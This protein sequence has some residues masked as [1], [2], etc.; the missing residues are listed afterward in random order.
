M[1]QNKGLFKKKL[2]IL[3]SVAI[4]FFIL[5][6]FLLIIGMLM[7]SIK[8]QEMLKATDK[9]INFKSRVERLIFTNKTLVQGF[10]AYLLMNP[11]LDEAEA[12]IY[13]DKL[14]SK[15]DNQ[16]RNIGVI[17]DTTIIWN[18]PKEGNAAAIGVDLSMVESQKDLIL[19]VKN[20]LEPVLQGPVDLVQGGTGFIIR[21]PI[22][23]PET[24]YWGQISIVLNGDKIIEEIN[25]YAA[26]AG[27]K[28]AI[29]NDQN[30]RVPF[31]G[32]MSIVGAAP[33][34][35]DI[36][37]D[38]INWQVVVS[39]KDGWQNN[40]LFFEGAILFAF[41]IAAGAGQLTYRVLKTNDQLRIMSSHDSLT[42]LFNRHYLN[43]YQAM[44][45]AAAK[46]S[47]RHVGFIS[48]D[49]NHFKKINDTYGHNVGDLV[50]VET[51]R[52]LKG[53]TRTNEAVF[54]LGGDEFLIIM[55]DIED[56]TVLQQ[57]RQRLIKSFKDDFHLVEYPCKI[58]VSIGTSVFPEDGNNIDALL[59]IADE[60]MYADKKQQQLTQA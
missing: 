14:L 33:L 53:C 57:T 4:A 29:F 11:D 19:K 16:I 7:N 55:P 35:F 21:L 59:Q 58:A 54:R 60:E 8:Q 3:I 17:Q 43:E 2:A 51:A 36:D 46:R 23:R 47:N 37:P 26:D 42:G 41:L 18:Y 30:K 9:F 12:D 38:F 6:V 22:I 49:L 48:M 34:D 25:A 39:P 40:Q 20:E 45:L 28:V 56:G 1:D 5:M 13:M 44:V 32:A 52:V 31:Y 10:E 50:L 15:N 27:L 24:G